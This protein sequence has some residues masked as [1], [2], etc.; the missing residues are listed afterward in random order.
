MSLGGFYFVFCSYMCMVFVCVVCVR[1]VVRR[2][3]VC[4]CVV[5]SGSCVFVV[6]VVYVFLV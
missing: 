3:C 2:L 4:V 1:C 5:F 6:C